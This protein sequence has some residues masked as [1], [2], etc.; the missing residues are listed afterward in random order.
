MCVAPEDRARVNELIRDI[1]LGELIPAPVSFA[2]LDPQGGAVRQVRWT[3]RA[4]AGEGDAPMGVAF[5]GEG[6]EPVERLG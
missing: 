1:L 4:L 3:V 6:P 5:M 2:V